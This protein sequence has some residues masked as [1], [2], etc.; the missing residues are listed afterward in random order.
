MIS[1][2]AHA[3]PSGDWGLHHVLPALAAFGSTVGMYLV[4]GRAAIS[5]LVRRAAG[6]LRSFCTRRPH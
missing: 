6:L 1:V 2:F 3:D 5:K 4:L